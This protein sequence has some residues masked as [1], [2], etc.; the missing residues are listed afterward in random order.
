M[1]LRH[2]RL[3]VTCFTGTMFSNSNSRQGHKE[4]Q[5]VCTADGWTRAFPMAKEKDAHEALLLLFNRDGVP[6]VMV[7]D[8]AN[9]QIQGGPTMEIAQGWMSHQKEG[10]TH[11]QIKCSRRFHQG[12]ET[13]CW[14]LNGQV[15]GTN[16][17]M[18]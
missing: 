13:R 6:S 7:M 11:A 1:Q 17:D 5:V 16:A 12:T 2:L 3:P 10:S 9:A 4:A 8:G 18:G 15:R 14:A